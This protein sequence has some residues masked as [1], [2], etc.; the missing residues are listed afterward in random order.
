M[1]KSRCLFVLLF[2]LGPIVGHAQ[3]NQLSGLVQSAR[4]AASFANGLVSSQ[5]TSASQADQS[6]PYSGRSM[7]GATGQGGAGQT[8]KSDFEAAK[9]AASACP[10]L[11]DEKYSIA[12]RVIRCRNDGLSQVQQMAF[13]GAMPISAQ[14]YMAAIVQDVYEDNVT[15]PSMGKP[16]NDYYDSCYR[17]GTPCV[18]KRW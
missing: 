3:L 2:A 1:T 4:D 7:S 9:R 16:I 18:R 12:E 8:T 14:G 15:D 10:V 17:R 6:A 13:V 5:V 11:V